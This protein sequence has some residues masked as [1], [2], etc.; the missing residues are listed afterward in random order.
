MH[1][2]SPLNRLLAARLTRTRTSRRPRAGVVVTAVFGDTVFGAG[3]SVLVSFGFTVA[4]VFS[5]GRP[6]A[7]VRVSREPVPATG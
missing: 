5:E 1:R 7:P 4:M 2:T 6:G 3:V